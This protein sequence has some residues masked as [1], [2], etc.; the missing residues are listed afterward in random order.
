[1]LILSR[2]PYRHLIKDYYMMVENHYE[3]AREGRPERI[4]TIDMGRR[5]IHNEGA[6][7]LI[8]RLG[9]KIEMDQ[10]TARR[11]FTLMCALNQS[12]KYRL[13]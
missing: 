4:Q 2:T 13:L 5:G 12:K 6:E 10:K 3:A 8:E 11:I 1:M 7:L 9:N